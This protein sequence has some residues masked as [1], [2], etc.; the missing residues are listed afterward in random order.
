MPE[1]RSAID[2]VYFDTAAVSLLYARGSVSRLVALA[3]R[4][5]VIFGSDFPLLSPARQ[6]R[7]L[8][9][10]LDREDAAAVCGGNAALLFGNRRRA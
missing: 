2:S 8:Q 9:D 6:L 7:D 5:R 3:G 4:E 10:L 1:V